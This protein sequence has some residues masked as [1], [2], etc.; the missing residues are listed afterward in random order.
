MNLSKSGT[1]P[2]EG[3]G[4]FLVDRAGRLRHPSPAP[5]YR[6]V[7]VWFN[8]S[9]FGRKG[10]IEVIDGAFLD[11]W[12]GDGARGPLLKA[13]GRFVFTDAGRLIGQNGWEGASLI[14]RGSDPENYRGY[15]THKVDQSAE[16]WQPLFD[17]TRQLDGL[18]TPDALFAESVGQIIDLDAFFRVL[19]TRTLIGDGDAFLI[20]NGHNGHLAFDSHTGR[21]QTIPFDVEAGFRGTFDLLSSLDPG[22]QRLLD[23]PATRRVYL[24]V[25]AEIV[26]GYWSPLASRW[27]AAVQS[28]TGYSVTGIRNHIAAGGERARAVI[29]DAAQLAFEITT[30]DGENFAT[31]VQSLRLLGVAPLPVDRILLSRSGGEVRGQ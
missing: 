3:A 7:D 27:L 17:L 18:Q 9:S 23:H 8:G 13:N 6:W 22:I 19:A 31:D 12:Q 29:G 28:A 5:I 25:L 30:N 1:S 20:N 4:L 2:N 15:F 14:A 11:K 10:D 21:W 26:D 16:A 24:R